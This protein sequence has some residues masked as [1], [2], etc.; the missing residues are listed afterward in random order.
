[1]VVWNRSLAVVVVPSILAL[2]MISLCRLAKVTPICTRTQDEAGSL[3]TGWQD[4][5]LCMGRKIGVNRLGWFNPIGIVA[6]S[7]SLPLAVN[8]I[9][10]RASSL[11][12]T[13]ARGLGLRT[14]HTH[15]WWNVGGWSMGGD[16]ALI[17]ASDVVQ[18]CC[19]LGNGGIATGSHC[20][21]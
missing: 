3:A 20:S 14:L 10:T 13:H 6:F 2:K 7:M 1:V 19:E 4:D 17:W 5:W 11:F 21:S 9:F 8:T 12:N 18:H 16:C 15:V